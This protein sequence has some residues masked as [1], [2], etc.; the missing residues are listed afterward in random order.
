MQAKSKVHFAAIYMKKNLSN[1]KIKKLSC[2]KRKYDISAHLKCLTFEFLRRA[3]RQSINDG[4]TPCFMYRRLIQS[5][6]SDLIVSHRFSRQ[7]K[8]GGRWV[9]IRCCIT[10]DRVWC[11][12]VRNSKHFFPRLE[13]ETDTLKGCNF[14]DFSI[15]FKVTEKYY[16]EQVEKLLKW[17]QC[18][19]YYFISSWPQ[20]DE[21]ASN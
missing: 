12:N 19:H 21:T 1:F 17:Q 18:E 11:E 6:T 13:V 14:A 3:R 9:V 10:D 2:P 16:S 20:V 7:R 15:Y 5:F 8:S 4:A